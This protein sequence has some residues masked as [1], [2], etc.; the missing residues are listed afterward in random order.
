MARVVVV[1]HEKSENRLTADQYYAALAVGFKELTD[2]GDAAAAL[3]KFIPPGTVGM[4]VNCLCRKSNSTPVPLV[5]AF[6]RLLGE[7]GH[8]EDQMVVWERT[9]S[10]L[11]SAGFQLNA[12]GKKRR[13]I[14]TDANNLGYGR[15]FYSFGRVDSLVS[16]ILTDL[17]DVN[18]NMALLKD[19]SI[20]G[21]SA[22]MK[23]MYGAIHNPN[24]FHDNNC[25]PFC[26][27]VNNLEPIREK[28]RLTIVDAARVQYDGGPGFMAQFMA[29]Y[30]GLI[31][32][33]DPVAA[34]RIGLEIVERLRS[35]N[36]RPPLKAVGRGVYYLKTAAALD[37][38]VEE[39]EQID[40]RVVSALDSQSVARGLFG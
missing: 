34:D 29:A 5:D 22:G 14:G 36:N 38:G 19:H 17:V 18:V 39:L 25:D 21:L 6:C 40:L 7:A 37:L 11:E 9:S 15:R 31:L 24:K 30:N 23:N 26:A 12:A 4:K 16:R 2:E 10:E 35:D 20:A 28:N 13:C 8:A 1:K 3:K 33:D 27:H 32:S